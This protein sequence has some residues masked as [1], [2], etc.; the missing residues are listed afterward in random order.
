MA[1]FKDLMRAVQLDLPI[2]LRAERWLLANADPVYTE[3]AIQFSDDFLRGKV[4]GNRKNRKPHFRASGMSKCGRARVFAR[5]GHPEVSAQY[6][7]VQAN[8]FATGNVL[9]R[10]W[11]MSGLTEGWLT[12]AEVP[13]ENEE[14]DLAGTADGVIYDGSLFEFKSINSR[15]WRWVQSQGQANDDHQ[16]QIGAY[17]LLDSTLVAASVVYENKDT[18]EWREF[19]TSF[20]NELMD[21]VR[22][23]LAGL[24]TAIANRKL[25]PVLPACSVK[26]GMVY[27]RC[28]YRDNCLDIKIWPKEKR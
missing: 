2:T 26:E 18:G 9:H 28:P 1:T 14:L 7:S 8:I 10:K 24:R 21:R 6:S 19:R 25:P 23:E 16:M 3:E 27:R 13:M 12:A 5:I 20:T 22:T 11:Q 4:G 15:G 17:K